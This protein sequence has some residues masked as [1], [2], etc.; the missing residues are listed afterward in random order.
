MIPW[1][2][3]QILYIIDLIKK[4]RKKEE[5]TKKGQNHS[6]ELEV[7]FYQ[8]FSLGNKSGQKRI[9]ALQARSVFRFS[10]LT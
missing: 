9:N 4:N 3:I 7:C 5:N 10:P 1:S 8:S 2:M 6:C